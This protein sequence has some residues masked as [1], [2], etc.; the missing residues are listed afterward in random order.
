MAANDLVLKS[1]IQQAQTEAQAAFGNAGVYLEKYIERP[2]HVEVQIIA[3]H[4]GNVL[5][6]WEREC[7]TQRRH[8]KLMKR[9]RHQICPRD[10]PGDVRGGRPAD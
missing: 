6:V 10:P 8:Q 7:S 5:H 4:H 2:R 3:D 9:A 1:A